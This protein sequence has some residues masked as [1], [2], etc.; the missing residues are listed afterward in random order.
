MCHLVVVPLLKMPENAS[1]GTSP[2]WGVYIYRIGTLG[3]YLGQFL[4]A[5][6]ISE[7]L[8]HYGLFLVYFVAKNRPY[9]SS[10][11]LANNFLTLKVPKKCGSILVTSLQMHEKTTSL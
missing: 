11:F 8:P 6:G 9:L 7:P 3:G 10:H 1:S 4:L 5:A 2:T